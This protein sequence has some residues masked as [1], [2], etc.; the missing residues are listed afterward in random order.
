MEDRLGKR[1]RLI[2]EVRSAPVNLSLPSLR[3]AGSLRYGIHGRYDRAEMTLVGHITDRTHVI[4]RIQVD[5][6]VIRGASSL[7][8]CTV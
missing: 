7:V 2:C 3:N 8:S 4:R 5:S 6:V 1:A